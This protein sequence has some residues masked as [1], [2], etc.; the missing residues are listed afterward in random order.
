MGARGFAQQ[1]ANLQAEK[2]VREACADQCCDLRQTRL[3][4][5]WAR[6]SEM[7]GK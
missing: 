2:L 5:Q 4:Q 7:R 6:Q 3:D 1:A